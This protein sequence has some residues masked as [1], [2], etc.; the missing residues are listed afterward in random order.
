MVT[1]NILISMWP[2]IGVF[3][4]FFFFISGGQIMDIPQVLVPGRGREG[5]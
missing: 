1:P 5:A 2:R 3:F 4:F